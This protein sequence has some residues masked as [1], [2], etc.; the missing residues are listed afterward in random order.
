MNELEVGDEVEIISDECGSKG[1][2][3]TITSINSGLASTN[4]CVSLHP[5]HCFK[6]IM[7]VNKME[8]KDL[9]KEN[10]KEAEKQYKEEK[11]NAEIEF[12]KSELRSITDNLN[13]L[14]RQIK[15]LEERKK[16]YLEK[17]KIFG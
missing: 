14:D 15:A 17:I 7:G 8:L 16:P 5:F 13:E 1:Q 10:I 11:K 4:L 3:A 6:K 12:A 9:K 2:K